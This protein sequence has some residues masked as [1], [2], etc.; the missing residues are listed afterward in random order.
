MSSNECCCNAGAASAGAAGA[1]GTAQGAAADALVVEEPL[2]RGMHL[3]T[4]LLHG[5]KT[6]PIKP[7]STTPPIYQTSAYEYKDAEQHALVC[8]GRAAGFVYTRLGN[9]TVAAF[10]RQMA[11]LEGGVAAVATASG[12]AATFDAV[13]NIV[14]AGDHIVCA[15]T[16]YGGTIEMFENLRDFGIDTTYVPAC[17]VDEL[18]EVVDERTRIIFAETLSNPKLEVLD[19]AAVAA[20]AHERGIALIVDNTV[21]TP[22]LCRPLDLGADLVVESSSKYING[23]GNGISGVV[24]DGGHGPW[25]DPAHATLYPAFAKWKKFGPMAFVAKMRAGIFHNAGAC[26]APQ[27]AFMNCMGLETLSVRMER[28]CANAKALAEFFEASGLVTEVRYPGL[29]SDEGHAVAERQFGGRGFGAMV[30]IRV[31]SQER[32]WKMIDALKIP[33]RVSNIGDTKTL[34]CHPAS[35]IFCEISPEEQRAAGVFDDSIRISVGIEDARD[36]VADFKQALEAADAGAGDGAG[37]D[38]ADGAGA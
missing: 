18:A 37:A 26:L 22:Y 16:L 24:I 3:D 9:P 34:V 33:L 23:H 27:N 15:A 20:F 21:A 4:A 12:M 7:D 11:A 19:I 32:A 29:A 38:G 35:T 2:I 17:T 1:T 31:G 14:R 25:R 5:G 13:T 10:E 30:A 6:D 28:A 8:Q 36:L